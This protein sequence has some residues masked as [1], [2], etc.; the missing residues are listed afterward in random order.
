[1][2]DTGIKKSILET[3]AYFDLFRY[4]LTEWEM[5]KWLWKNDASLEAVQYG[6]EELVSTKKISYKDG[7]FF[8]PGNEVYISERR[9]K[10]LIADKKY[11]KLKRIVSFLQVI[12]F[13]R[14]VGS[15][16]TMHI[17][18]FRE[19]SDLDVFVI[20]EKNRMWTARFLITLATAIIGQWRHGSHIKDKV[21][22]SFYITTDELS[23]KNIALAEDPYLAYWINFVVPLL[24]RDVY[25][26]FWNANSWVSSLIP[27]G[28]P[29]TAIHRRRIVHIRLLEHVRYG[30]EKVLSRSFGRRIEKFLKKIQIKKM[31]TK[32]SEEGR[33][34]SAI[35]ITDTML[36]FHEIDRKKLYRDDWIEKMHN[37]NNV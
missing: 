27:N 7:L 19:S 1:M 32:E 8:L 31:K 35:V 4:P 21:C 26:D 6:L 22:L 9:K 13:I 16:N 11:K 2:E 17:L 14:F 25:Q 24:D 10:Y 12:P 33:E 28:M 18:D 29:Y 5:W 23:L 15:C 37:I 3:I 36:K 34:K 30:L 20:I